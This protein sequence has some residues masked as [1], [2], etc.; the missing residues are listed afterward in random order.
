MYDNVYNSNGNNIIMT[1]NPTATQIKIHLWMI[2]EI[3]LFLP[4]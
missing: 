4:V 3:S 2:S 1:R